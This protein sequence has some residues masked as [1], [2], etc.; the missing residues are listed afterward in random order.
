MKSSF[1]VIVHPSLSAR[2]I[3]SGVA[4]V[5]K[6]FNLVYDT[7]FSECYRLLPSHKVLMTHRKK[8]HPGHTEDESNIITWNAT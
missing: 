2:L 4:F 8:D 1:G 5:E 7:F 3:V 6:R